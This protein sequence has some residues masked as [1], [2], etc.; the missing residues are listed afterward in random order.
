MPAAGQIVMGTAS[1]MQAADAHAQDVFLYYCNCR[2]PYV[3]IG[4]HEIDR[5]TRLVRAVICPQHNYAV[6]CM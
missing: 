1:T 4:R 5:E 2:A 3:K 6:D